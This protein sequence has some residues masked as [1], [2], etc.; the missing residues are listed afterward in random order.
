MKS[1]TK[2]VGHIKSQERLDCQL[3]GIQIIR[4][5]LGVGGYGTM[6]PISQGRG[7]GSAKVSREIK[8]WLYFC[9]ICLF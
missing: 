2:A 6:S 3:R 4:D 9:H 7:R 5:A 8:K 1:S